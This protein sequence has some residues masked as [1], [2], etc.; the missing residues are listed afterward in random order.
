M[1][2]CIPRCRIRW[3]APPDDNQQ[4][5]TYIFDTNVRNISPDVAKGEVLLS[6]VS[7]AILHYQPQESVLAK[8]KA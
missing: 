8:P 3:R 4:Q 1:A 7:I 6:P 2:N 5:W